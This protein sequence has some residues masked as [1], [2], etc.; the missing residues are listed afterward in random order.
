MKQV[1]IV[2][3]LGY[4]D[5]GKGSTTAFLCCK[6]NNPLVI[7]Y[8]GGHQAGHTVIY[9]NHRHVFSNFGSGTL[10]GVPTYWSEYCTFYPV[11]VWNEWQALKQ[12]R[13]KLFVHPLAP[14]ATPFDKLFNEQKEAENRHGSCG[15]GF[16]ATWARHE[17]NHKIHVQDL[18][19]PKVLEQKLRLMLKHYYPE[20]KKPPEF[21]TDLTWDRI[22]EQ[23]LNMCAG[24]REIIDLHIDFSCYD[25][26]VFEGAQGILL[27]KD[28]GFFPNVT[29]GNTTTKNAFAI[30]HQQLEHRIASL[31]KA[32]NVY[33]VTRTY[34]TR[35]GNGP[36]TNED[37]P[38]KLINNEQETNVTNKWQGKLRTAM[39]DA[40]MLNYALQCD[41]YFVDPYSEKNLVLTCMDQTGPYFQFSYE[42]GYA[43]HQGKESLLTHLKC[44]FQNVIEGKAATLGIYC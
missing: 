25:H 26:Y 27:D 16:G 24:V 40:D 37:M 21:S 7:R 17:A 36:L 1:S 39:L 23:F 5:E 31:Y 30:W 44:S 41:S 6:G 19:Y 35:H 13:P 2:V 11:G 12:F 10:Q 33:Y 29:R 8:S 20:Q 3:G 4:G 9:N 14:V 15:V 22:L 34:Q 18:F 38:P 42:N 43:C 32:P 28:F